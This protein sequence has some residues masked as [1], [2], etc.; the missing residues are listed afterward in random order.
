MLLRELPAAR[1]STRL[2]IVV[3]L[4]LGTEGSQFLI[5]IARALKDYWTVDALVDMIT[6]FQDGQWFAVSVW[7]WS[8]RVRVEVKV[9]E[10]FV[11]GQNKSGMK[12]CVFVF[13]VTPY[14][15]SGTPRL[16]SRFLGRAFF[17]E[18]NEK[19]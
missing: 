19:E 10:L 5:P 6:Q 9:E 17:P 4:P 3:A 14:Y 13:I 16:P 12:P 2:I 11:N 15:E 7:A 18:I 8:T 1:S